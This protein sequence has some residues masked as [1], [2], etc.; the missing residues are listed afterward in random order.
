MKE[1]IIII[2]EMTFTVAKA[3]GILINLILI[4]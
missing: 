4:Q 3:K 2:P 1:Y